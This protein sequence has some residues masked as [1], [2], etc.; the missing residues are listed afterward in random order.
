[1]QT[2]VL[3]CVISCVVITVIIIIA[4]NNHIK[5]QPHRIKYVKF[6]PNQMMLNA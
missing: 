2:S 1:M 4:A 6:L 3:V 5:E